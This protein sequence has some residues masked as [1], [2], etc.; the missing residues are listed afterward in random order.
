MNKNTTTRLYI[1]Y[2]IINRIRYTCTRHLRGNGF[3][4]YYYYSEKNY[5]LK[6]CDRPEYRYERGNLR[7]INGW[8]NAIVTRNRFNQVSDALAGVEPA[9]TW[10][11]IGDCCTRYTGIE[12]EHTKN[13]RGEDN[14]WI[15]IKRNEIDKRTSRW[16]YRESETHEERAKK[17]KKQCPKSIAHRATEHKLLF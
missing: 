11:S 6:F 10:F 5:T 12:R 7:V 4:F 3:R 2:T 15:L 13:I 1:T 14:N 9:K 17:K 16:I 8:G